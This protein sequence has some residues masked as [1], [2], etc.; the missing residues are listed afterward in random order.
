M[1]C[2]ET[3]GNRVEPRPGHDALKQEASADA[4]AGERTSLPP[5]SLLPAFL[6]LL[7]AKGGLHHDIVGIHPYCPC[8]CNAMV[9]V[10]SLTMVLCW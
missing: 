4:P 1:D 9:Q 3:E 5:S 8:A 10:L 6:S 2:R 7:S